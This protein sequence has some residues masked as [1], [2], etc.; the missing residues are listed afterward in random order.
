MLRQ[1]SRRAIAGLG[2]VLSVAVA[3]PLSIAPSASA[4][5]SNFYF[6]NST[7]YDVLKLYMSDSNDPKWRYVGDEIGSGETSKINFVNPYG[8]PCY[9]DFKWVFPNGYTQEVRRVNV[10]KY[11]YYQITD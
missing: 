7:S 3:L 8:R 11:D 2:F 5:K 10:C 4:A 9:Y 6:V 1:L